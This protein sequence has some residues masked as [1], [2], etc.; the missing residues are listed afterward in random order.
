MTT[1]D[2][3]QDNKAVENKQNDKEYNFRKLENQLNQERAARLELEKKLEE[4]NR[5]PIQ[6]ETEEDDD[7]PYVNKK[8]ME[9]KF[10][11]FEKKM[12]QRID[13]RA[14]EKARGMMEKEKQDNWLRNNPDFYEVMQHAEKFA[15]ADPELAETILRMPEGFDRQKLVYKNIKSM[16]FNKP[17]QKQSTIQDKIDANK[18]S[19]FY[20]PSGVGTSP[21]SSQA[22][23]SQGG[24]KQ[25][26][27]K[28]KELQA[29][30]RI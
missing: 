14:E 1:P 28:M 12:E 9:S 2:Q 22:D 21:Y 20:Q 8:R 3:N 19:P 7:E 6:Q 23:F 29:R 5:Q 10:N 27:D 11:S 15:E 24:Q 17:A 30:L 18:R 25:A 13:Q 4:R 16:G 26:Y